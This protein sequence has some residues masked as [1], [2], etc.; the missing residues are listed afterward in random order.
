MMATSQ[1]NTGGRVYFYGTRYGP[2]S[3]FSQHAESKFTFEAE[4]DSGRLAVYTV[5]SAEQYMM[6]H[7]AR[8]FGDTT[9]MAKLLG[10]EGRNPRSAK[11]I[12]RSVKGFD[13]QVWEKHRE[14]VVEQGNY[15]KYAQNVA[16]KQLLLG[17]GTKELV[18]A[19]P[20][21]RLWGIGY[22]QKHADRHVDE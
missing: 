5:Y 9:S 3:G 7:K 10:S 12:G 17:T 1:E 19:S 15:L 6:Y 4:D 22:S 2:C 16:L 21:D 13:Q 20:F 8:I 18:E 14:A 11:T